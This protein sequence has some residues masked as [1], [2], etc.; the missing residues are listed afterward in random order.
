[1]DA[2]AKIDP[3]KNEPVQAADDISKSIFNIAVELTI[4]A[5]IA[6]APVLAVPVIKAVFSYFVRRGA[7][8]LYS[9]LETMMSFAIINS[10]VQKQREQYDKAV[11]DLKTAQQNGDKN[12]REKAKQDFKDTLRKLIHTDGS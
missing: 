3:P 1:M 2:K 6:K 12:A 10:Q 9:Q 7:N 11:V 5:M 4:D 8:M